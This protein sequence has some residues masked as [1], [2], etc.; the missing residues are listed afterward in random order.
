V[1]EVRPLLL[2]SKPWLGRLARRMLP[3]PLVKAAAELASPLR[4]WETEYVPEGWARASVDPKITGWNAE[5]VRD[6]YLA[7]WPSFVRAA[8]GSGPLGIHHEVTAG[9]PVKYDD[10]AAHNWVMAFGYVLALAAS[11][12]DLVSILDW[13]GALGHYY[14]LGKAVMPDVE[15]E[16]HCKEVPLL[17][18]SGRELLPEVTFHD[19]ERCLG[20]AYDLVLASGSLQYSEAWSETLRRLGTAAG[21]YLYVTRL[22]V[23]HGARSFVAVERAYAYGYDAEYLGWVLNRDELLRCAYESGMALMREFVVSDPFSIR[24]APEQVELRGFLFRPTDERERVR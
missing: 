12:R 6:A 4:S 3:P 23:V 8:E 14:L 16:Y 17:C 21:R 15:I 9:N 5:A 7:K 13:G 2:K 24:K 19:D 22:P 11:K 18:A 1:I 10:L 20:R